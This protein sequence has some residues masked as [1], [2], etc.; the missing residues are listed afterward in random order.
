M[1]RDLHSYSSGKAGTI[2]P[3][4]LNPLGIKRQARKVETLFIIHGGADSG[5]QLYEDDKRGQQH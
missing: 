2:V 3:D 5:F 4:E 1:Y